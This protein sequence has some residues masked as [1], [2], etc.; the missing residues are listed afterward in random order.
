MNN[1]IEN[2]IGDNIALKKLVQS[3]KVQIE[4]IEK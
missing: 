3:G 1:D 2:I 4:K